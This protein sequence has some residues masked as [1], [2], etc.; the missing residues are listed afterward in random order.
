MADTEK[1]SI[2]LDT[3]GPAP[4]STRRRKRVGRGTAAGQGRT[5]G[6]GHKGQKSR[7]GYKQ[8][9]G[10]EGGQM[11]IQRRLPKRGFSNAPFRKVYQIVN[12]KRLVEVF[13]DAG[14]VTPELL[15]ERGLIKKSRVPV[16]LLGDGEIKVALNLHVHAAT[17]SAVEKVKA[18]GGEV[19]LIC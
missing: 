19:H 2:S 14:D 17:Q 9:I 10:F 8:K 6:R 5:C 13:K 18:A 7:A 3:I 1:S 15:L 4:G 12:L 16:K 11:P